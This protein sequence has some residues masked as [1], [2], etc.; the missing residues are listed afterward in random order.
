MFTKCKFAVSSNVP[1]KPLQAQPIQSTGLNCKRKDDC[2]L[3]SNKENHGASQD[4]LLEEIRSL[5]Q[6]VDQLQATQA[7]I[8]Q[9]LNLGG[10]SWEQAL[11]S[12][13]ALDLPLSLKDISEDL[14]PFKNSKTLQYEK[15]AFQISKS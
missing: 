9:H 8:L 13:V 4:R 12:S 6:R 3:L 1:Q 7:T 14:D 2:N 11:Q 5:H 10:S 15:F